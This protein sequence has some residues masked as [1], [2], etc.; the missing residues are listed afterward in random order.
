MDAPRYIFTVLSMPLGAFALAYRCPRVR[1][2]GP[3]D[4]SWYICGD[5]SMPLGALKFD[6]KDLIELCYQMPY[7]ASALYSVTV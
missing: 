7:S 1:S 2:H 3:I 5:L 6:R 4:A